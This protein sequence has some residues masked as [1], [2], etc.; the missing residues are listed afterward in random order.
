[1]YAC[2]CV[3][4]GLARKDFLKIE[5]LSFRTRS[6]VERREGKNKELL[7]RRKNIYKFLNV[8]AIKEN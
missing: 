4:M 5:F 3:C 2:M 1:M 7:K 8:F 6:E